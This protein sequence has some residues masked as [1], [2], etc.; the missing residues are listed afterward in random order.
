MATVE[1]L[2]AAVGKWL[3]AALYQV[4]GQQLQVARERGLSI[5]KIGLLFRA[6][7]PSGGVFELG[8]EIGISGAAASQMIDQLVQRGLLTRTESPRDRRVKL[9]GLTEEGQGILRCFTAATQHWAEQ[10]VPNMSS[11][12]TR[13]VTEAFKILN[14]Y[15][16][17]LPFDDAKPATTQN[18]SEN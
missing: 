15:T 5:P 11:D 3:S 12:E 7:N 6:V 2:S 10:L 16:P 9:I 14:R 17:S 18:E 13:V 4:L 1:P 8:Q